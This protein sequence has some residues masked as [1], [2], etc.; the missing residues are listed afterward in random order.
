M[1]RSSTSH[2]RIGF[3]GDPL[4]EV[5]EQHPDGDTR[6]PAPAARGGPPAGPRGRARRT[7]RSPASDR[8]PPAPRRRSDGAATDSS[9]WVRSGPSSVRGTV[10][11]AHTAYPANGRT[12]A[13]G[14]S[15]GRRA[16][17]AVR[18]A[19]VTAASTARPSP[20]VHSDLADDV[21]PQ[22]PPA[23]QVDRAQPPAA[24]TSRPAGSSEVAPRKR[25]GCARPRAQRRTPGCPP[26]TGQQR[27]PATT[28]TFS[29]DRVGH[30]EAGQGAR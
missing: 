7:G 5:A 10:T 4:G 29:P 23:G 30:G 18:G 9:A 27:R 11:A 17:P 20:T 1:S 2:G 16:Q 13:S 26:T 3:A 8:R 14:A 19:Q 25:L 12:T 24:P 6:R 28:G 22:P 15:Q 21:R